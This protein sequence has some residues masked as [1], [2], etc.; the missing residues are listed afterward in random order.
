[1]EKRIILF[2]LAFLLIFIFSVNYPVVASDSGHENL[3]STVI[4]GSIAEST[5][6]NY[7][8]LFTPENIELLGKLLSLFLEE[9]GYRIEEI[10]K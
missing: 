4:N 8:I 2:V 5:Y 3:E 7:E 9:K 6:E 10:E 1:M